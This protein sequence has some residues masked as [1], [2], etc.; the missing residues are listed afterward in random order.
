MHRIPPTACF[1]LLAAACA[2]ETPPPATRIDPAR[3]AAFA[4]LPAAIVT[5]DNP[6]TPAKVDL[7]R[8]LFYETRLSRAQDLSCN[9]CHRLPDY[10]VDAAAVSEGFRGQ[11]GTR[12]A[13]TVYNAAG[14]LA[15]FWDGR[16]PTVEEQAKGPILN[17]A[18][19]AMPSGAA[20]LQELG[21]IAAYREAFRRAF[22]GEAQP[23][24]YD[25]VGRAIGAFERRLVTPSPW[26]AFLQGNAA[27]LTE[28]ERAGFNAF[29][30]AGCAGCHT[31]TYVGGTAYQKVGLAVPWPAL[32]DPGRSA[33]THQPADRDVF[34]IPS[35]R[36]VAMTAPYFHTGGT[37]S[38]EEAVRLMGRHQLGRELSEAQ[39]TAIVRWLRALTGTIPR[40]YIAPRPPADR[41]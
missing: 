24:T 28:R 9:S 31:G 12:N 20:V 19:M 41:S 22:P 15:Q 11:R 3:L 33:V 37:A 8:M 27:A 14:H 1:V 4:P 6:L 38:L 10:G 23:I 25:N 17:P 32:A 18:E 21:A 13:P 5:A 16:A 2:R 36:N 29:V 39:V 7:G 26:D 34:K 30:E 40:D 35:L